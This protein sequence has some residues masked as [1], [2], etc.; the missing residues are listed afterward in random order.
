MSGLMFAGASQL[1]ALEVWP[2]GVD[3]RRIVTLA[4]VVATVNN[5]L[6]LMGAALRPGSDQGGLAGYSSC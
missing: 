2:A 3:V 1:V 4:V 5:A 6:L